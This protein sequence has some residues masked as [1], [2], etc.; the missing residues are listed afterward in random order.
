VDVALTLAQVPQGAPAQLTA[1]IDDRRYSQANGAEPSQVITAAEYYIDVPPWVT[2][3]API[4]YPLAAA[5]GLFDAP[6]EAVQA[7]VTTSALA[8][9]RHTLYVRGR[10]AAGNW[11]AITAVFLTVTSGPQPDLLA[12]A[13][14]PA[15]VPIVQGRATV[16]ATVTLSDGTPTPG[17]P[18]TFTLDLGTMLPPLVYADSNGQA[19][20]TLYAG[21]E[22]GEA[23]I[24][25][26]APGLVTGPV[27]VTLYIPDPP[28]AGFTATPSVCLGLVVRFTNTSTAPLLAPA[29]YLWAFGDG[30]TTTKSSPTHLYAAAGT[31]S[32]TLTASNAGGASVYSDTVEVRP[33]PEASWTYAPVFP[34][35]GEVVQ[36]LAQGAGDPVAWSWDFGDGGLSSRQNPTHTFATTNTYTVTLRAGNDCWSEPQARVVAVGSGALRFYLPLIL[37]H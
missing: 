25:A 9:G 6:S 18:V 20:A 31:Y 15:S 27:T 13:A 36:F 33:L 4:S 22:P 34:A 5:D 24:A 2:S 11:G 14:S 28:V 7:L 12:L 29:S 23:A 16:T 17:W 37:A 32:V 35:P 26:Q 19:V 1:T 30:R 21:G 10:D 8:P 3:T